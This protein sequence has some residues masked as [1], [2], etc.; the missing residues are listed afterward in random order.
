M[1]AG[2]CT[3]MVLVVPFTVS[4]RIRPV[5]RSMLPDSPAVVA[6]ELN[7]LTAVFTRSYRL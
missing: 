5:M 7:R 3:A 2:F 1:R 6:R 4:I